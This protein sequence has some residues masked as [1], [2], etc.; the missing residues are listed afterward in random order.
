[1]RDECKMNVCR[2]QDECKMNACRH[3][4]ITHMQAKGAD[5]EAD[6]TRSG[7]TCMQMMMKPTKPGPA[8]KHTTSDALCTCLTGSFSEECTI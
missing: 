1:M 4:G 2:H 5:D 6:K 7:I 3:Q 8:Q